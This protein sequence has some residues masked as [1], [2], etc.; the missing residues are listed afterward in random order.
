MNFLRAKKKYGVHLH[1]LPMQSDGVVDLQ[2]LQ[3]GLSSLPSSARSLVALTHVQTNSSIIQPAAAV[4]EIAQKFKAI[5]L[6]DTCQSIGQIP[7]DIRS[8]RCDFACATGRKWLRG[9]RGTGFLYAKAS[10][11]AK[12]DGLV[13]E[14]AMIDHVAVTWSTPETQL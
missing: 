2:S 14:P 1:V 6:L 13:G 7:V 11:L 5:F 12:T 10:T 8:L 4:G 9:P 3:D